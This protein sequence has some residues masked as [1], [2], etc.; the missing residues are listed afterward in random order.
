[1]TNPPA[2]EFDELLPSLSHHLRWRDGGWVRTP[3]ALPPLPVSP[4]APT[5][6]PIPVAVV[7]GATPPVQQRP[8]APREHLATLLRA[9]ARRL[10]AWQGRPA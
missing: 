4:V 9:L 5:D 7:V 8:S 10:D 1:M 2:R 3:V 6:A